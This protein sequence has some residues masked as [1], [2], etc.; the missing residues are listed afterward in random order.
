MRLLLLAIALASVAGAGDRGSASVE[1]RVSWLRDN[2]IA[3]RTIAPAD[4]DF[5]DLR[6]LAG[7]L[8][9]ARVVILGEATH[10]DGDTFLAKA[11]FVRYLRREMG[12]DVLVFE[13]GFYDCWKAWK[14]VRAGE[15]PATAFRESVF[16][17]WTLSAQVQPLIEH[18]AAEARS[19]PPLELAGIDPQFT[20][21]LAGR[22]LLDD[23]A[24]LAA[25]VGVPPERVKERLA[26]PLANLIES[27]YE[28]GELPDASAR[29]A[30][31]D[32]LA[33]LESRLRRQEKDVP[34]GAFW[35]RLLVSTR[36]HAKVS[37]RM[38]FSRSVLESPADYGVRERLM[39]E[40]L[41][42]LA[43]ERFPDRKIVVW[44]HSGHSSRGQAGIEVPS[45]VHARLYR[46]LKSAGAVARDRLGSELYSVGV[47]AYQ[48]RYATV[49]QKPIELLQPT[50]GS[51]EDLFHR[52]GRAR[53]FLDLSRAD[54]LP[55]WLRQPVI[56]RPIGYKEMRARWRE[57]F[58]GL[59]FL[60]RMDISE[61]VPQ[62]SQGNPGLPK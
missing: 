58:D 27:R 56:A 7:I 59:L 1:S 37:W 28:N 11:R 6:P 14:R 19:E 22:F 12:F 34:E 55:H 16:R 52:T 48:G 45:P 18:F 9:G 47:L 51:L 8:A 17:I 31:L 20:G 25:R 21:E 44:M 61:R 24:G 30:L 3:L 50:S 40:H 10:G 33:E 29:A 42:W 15:D 41:I 38:D 5:S 2:A 13:S 57:V 46:T 62:A 23:L 32:T 39:G 53:A 54:R 26:A 4:D 60:D 36:E 35:R 49:F 43:R